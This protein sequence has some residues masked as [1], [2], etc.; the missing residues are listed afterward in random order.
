[1]NKLTKRAENGLAYLVSV[2]ESEQVVESKYPNTLKCITD[3][4]EKLATYEETGLE[5]CEVAG[6]VKAKAEGR[7]IELLDDEYKT[8]KLIEIALNLKLYDWQKTY[9]LSKGEYPMVGRRTGRTMA[10]I[11]KLCISDGEPIL[12]YECKHIALYSDGFHGHRYDDFFRDE[13]RNIYEQLKRHKGLKLR[14]IVFNKEDA[15]RAVAD[16]GRCKGRAESTKEVS[17]NE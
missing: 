9:I 7:L 3:S 8:I 15:E 12:M 5:P 4:F 10:Y 14:T 1:M 6:L 17:D 2:K 16:R 11:I 13:L